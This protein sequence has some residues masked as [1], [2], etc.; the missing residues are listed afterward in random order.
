M[1]GI[2]IVDLSSD[3]E[4][5]EVDVKSVR[6]QPG[7]VQ[8]RLYP[9]PQFVDNSGKLGAMRRGLVPR[10][11]YKIAQIIYM[12]TPCFFILMP[13]HITVAELLD[14][15]IDEIQNGATFVIVDK[16]SNPRDGSPALLIQDDGGGMDPEAMRRC[17]SF[18]FS[19]KKSKS[20][21]GQYGNGFKTS[22]MRLGADV[23]LFSQHLDDRSLTQSI[24]LLSYS[25]LTNAGH[26]RIVVPM[27]DYELNSSSGK[28]DVLHGR[29][30]FA[31]NLSI[32]LQWSPYSTKAEL[33]KQFDNIGTHGTKIII[34]NLWVN[35]DGNSELDFDSDEKD[36][37]IS[38]DTTK[39]NTY[40]SWKPVN[41]QHIARRYHNSLRVYLSILYLRIPETFRII[42]RGEIVEHHNIADD[43]KYIEYILYKPQSAGSV[44]GTVVSTIGFLKEAPQLNI[45]GF[46]VYHKNRLIMRGE[47]ENLKKSNVSDE[48]WTVFVDN[49]SKRVPRSVL[50]EYFNHYGQVVRIFIPRFLEKPKYKSS[51]FA[52]VQYAGEEGRKKAIQYANG[53][54]I[55]GRR[56]NV[57][58]A[59]YQ[60]TKRRNVAVGK[61]MLENRGNMEGLKQTAKGVRNV[62][63]MHILTENSDWVKRSLTGIIKSSFDQD[64]IKE[65]LEFEGV[66]VQISTWGYAWNACL[67]TFNTVEEFSNVWMNKKEEL[68]KMAKPYDDTSGIDSMSSTRSPSITLNTES[69]QNISITS[70]KLN[71]NNFLQ[72]SQSVKLFIR[73]RGKF[74]YLSGT[75]TKPAE[76]DEESERWEAENSMIMSWLINSMDPSVGRTYLFLPTAHDI[77]NAVNETY[78]DLGN[79]GQWALFQKMVE[80]ERVFEFL[81]GLN[82][83]LDEVRGRILG[84][85][86][87][88]STREVFSESPRR[89]DR[90]NDRD[91]PI[92]EHC[93]KPGHTKAK[94]CK[95]HGKLAENFSANRNSRNAK[96]FH[97]SSEDASEE[98]KPASELSAFSKEQLEQLYQLMSSHSISNTPNPSSYIASS[99]LA[100][101]DTYPTAFIASSKSNPWI[102]DSGATDHMIGNSSIFSSYFPLSGNLKV[103][104]ADGSLTSIAGKGSIIIS[105]SLTLLNVLHVPKLSCN[106]I[107][108][109][110]II[111]D[112]KC[113][114]TIT[115]AGFEF[116]DPCS[117]KMIG[118]AKEVDGLYHLVTDNP[119]DKQVKKPRCFT[120]LPC[121]NEIMLWHYR[122]SQPINSQP[123]ETR[124]ETNLEPPTELRVYS[125]RMTQPSNV[126]PVPRKFRDGEAVF[127]ELKALKKNDTWDLTPLPEG[128]RS[129]GSKW[130]FTIKYHADGSVERYKARLVA[131]GFTQTYGLD[132]EETFAPVAK[133]NTVR[134]LLSLAVNLD[135][136]LRQFDVKNAFLNGELE[137]EVFMEVPPGFDE[138]KKDGRVCKLKKSIYGLKQ[139]P[140]AW[141]E[142]FT[143]AVK[144]HG[145]TQA[146]SDHTMFYKHNNGKIAI[147]IVYVDDIVM[148]GDDTIE[149]ESLKNFLSNQFEVEDLGQLKYFLGMEVARSSKGIIISQRKYVLDILKETGLLGCKPVAT[150]IDPNQKLEKED[151]VEPVTRIEKHSKAVYR[152]LHYLKGSPGK[153]IMFS[154]NG[155][156]RVEIFT[157]V[158]WGG[159]STDRRSTTGYCSFVWG[160]LVTWRSKKQLVVS[161][162]SAEAEFRAMAQG[163]YEL[164]WLRRI[165]E[166]LKVE[167]DKPMK[168]YCDNKSAISIAQNPVQHD[169]TKHVEI[170]RHFIKER[171]ENGDICIPFVPSSEQLA[172]VLTKG[173]FTTISVGHLPDESKSRSDLSSAKVLLRVESP[174]D[175]PDTITIGSYGRSFKV[176]ISMGDGRRPTLAV[177]ENQEISEESRLKVISWLNK[178]HN[179]RVNGVSGGQVPS[180]KS[181]KETSN[182]GLSVFLENRTNQIGNHVGLGLRETNDLDD[183]AQLEDNW[184]SSS[185]IKKIIPG[186][187]AYNLKWIGGGEKNFIGRF[188]PD[189]NNISFNLVEVAEEGENE[190]VKE[191]TEGDRVF[192]AHIS[193]DLEMRNVSD[194]KRAGSNKMNDVKEDKQFSLN[195]GSFSSSSSRARKFVNQDGIIP[196]LITEGKIKAKENQMSSFKNLV[197]FLSRRDF[198]SKVRES[199][200][201]ERASSKSS[202]S[203]VK[204][205]DEA[206]A[207]ELKIISWNVG[208]L[209]KR[210][211]VRAVA[212]LIKRNKPVL[213]LLHDTKL[214][215]CQNALWRKL[216]ANLLKGDSFHPVDGSASGL[217]C[218]WNEDFF[219]VSSEHN[220]S[221][222]MA[223]SGKFK[224]FKSANLHR[225][226]FNAY[227]DPEEKSGVSQNWHSMDLFRSFVQQLNLMNLPGLFS[228][229]QGTKKVIRKWPYRNQRGISE[230]I[231]ELKGK[232]NDLE[233]KV[234]GGGIYSQE[235][236]Q[237]LLSRNELWKLHR[238]DESIWFQKS[239]MK[240]IKDGD[241]NTR[242]FHL[243]ALKRNRINAI[244]A[245]KVA[246]VE[247]SN[248]DHIRA[249]VLDF[250]K[251]NYNLKAML[252]VDEIYL[253]FAKL[254][255]K[256]KAGLEVKFSEQEVW[257]AIFYSDSAKS[258][259]LDGYTIGFFKKFW[260]TLK[261]HIMKFVD[262]FYCGRKWEHGVNHAFITLIPKKLNPKDIEDFRPISMVGSLYKIISKVLLKRLV[263]VIKGIVSP[264]QFAF[265]P[266]RQLLDCAF[267]AN[268]GIDFWRKQERKELVFKVD[269]RR[270]YDSMEWPILLTLLKVMGFSEK[271][272]SWIEY[273]ISLASISVLV[274]GSPTEE[275]PMGK[276][277]RQGCSLSPLLFNIVGELLNLM[278]I[279]VAGLGLFEGFAIGR[280]DNPFH[281]TH[282]QFADDL[283]LFYRDSPTHIL[284]IRRVLR[285]FS[286]MSGLHLNLS[287][288]SLY[289][290][291][292]EDDIL[293]EWAYEAGYGVGSFPTV[294]LGLP[295]GA[296][297]NSE[298]LWD[299]VIQKFNNR[300]AGWKASSLSMA[301]RLVLV[302]SVL[303]SL[304]IFF[305]YIFKILFKAS[306]KLNSLMAKF[307]W[308]KGS[309]KKRIHWVNWKMVCQPYEEG[310][311]R[312][313]DLNLVN[314]VLLGSV[315]SRFM[316]LERSGGNFE[317]NKWVWSGLAPPRVETF[318][319][320]DLSS[321]TG[322]ELWNRF[323][324]LWDVSSVLPQDPS[325]LLCS[326]SSLF[327]ISRF[328]LA[329]WFL[330]KFPH[331]L[332]QADLLV[333]DPS[334]A[335]RI[336]NQ[337]FKIK[338]VQCWLP[339]A[340][341][342]KFNMNGAV[343]SDGLQGGIG[344]ILKDS[345][346]TTLATFSN[347]VGPGPPPLAELKA[348]KKGI[349]F[350]LSSYWA[351]RG[352]LIIESD[353]KAAVDWILLPF[354]APTLF[355]SLVGEIGALVSTREIIVR[356]ILRSCTLFLLPLVASSQEPT[357]REPFWHVVSYTVSTGRGVVGVLE[358]NFIEPTHN[359][360]DFE[361]T[362]LF[363][364]LETRL[365]EMTYEY[366]HYHCELIGYQIKRKS[367]P[368]ASHVSPQFTGQSNVQE[369]VGLNQT[370]MVSN[371]SKGR[372]VDFAEQSIPISHG[373][374]TQGLPM[375]RKGQADMVEIEKGKHQAGTCGNTSQLEELRNETVAVQC[376]YERLVEELKSLNVFKDENI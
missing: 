325:S 83:E 117:G 155:S 145:Y 42:L 142:R 354:S 41:E 271:W 162:S 374:S 156:R 315:S 8:P 319:L 46:C 190:P 36:I 144:Q 74:G 206:A 255:A 166:E 139:S 242:F 332:I 194:E 286:L 213:L 307:F 67:I 306:Q 88:S 173:L 153:G 116:Q 64:L 19:D 98:P 129:V 291:N 152:I 164:L 282:L 234:Q 97:A 79:A 246:G 29:E 146:Q 231:S 112:C 275:F 170:D 235:W 147:L 128:K 69:F 247:I 13:P 251:K 174:F 237:L 186:G 339:P 284:N 273:C 105:P 17:M 52:F 43:L 123:R 14:N 134:V 47:R 102:I 27:V 249:Y 212:R 218:L 215:N 133:L 34:Y 287:K 328:R 358:A 171:L 280:P 180:S 38:G 92:C 366:W 11:R 50:R 96:G 30:H 240:W 279:K 254:S 350:F 216:G 33:L 289:V 4:L 28:L 118:N 191:N 189:P 61:M 281:L 182:C 341:F 101:K 338:K 122:I 161:R 345:N 342:F 72:W 99:S 334:L 31:F 252:E 346:C 53:T 12:C 120:T 85:E 318:L 312:V 55:D 131:R 200:E 373:R 183:K 37:R 371:R 330:A 115:F 258:S 349:D 51:T 126:P 18:G 302:K 106:L 372:C 82:K 103:K 238:M 16:T 264:S 148:T 205:R 167:R 54:W 199:L 135:W 236:D 322:R 333:G 347:G 159:S 125:R 357:K 94:C 303:S 2:E 196:V 219:E 292:M 211:K 15:A 93:N 210:E 95:L 243:C 78:S 253:N 296:K 336:P 20:T 119:S 169:M 127:K 265:I 26:D 202:H 124:V 1:N 84:R 263:S 77:W 66:V 58:I 214:N 160:N 288:S 62:W 7:S 177:A 245:L 73:G 138:L 179:S 326:C 150:P 331:V 226:N 299:P 368:P 367:Q 260:P 220:Q 76:E 317:W 22:S 136:T 308:G 111:H 351:L 176:K 329:K 56:I 314:R 157:D 297:K 39:V 178:G 204:A 130:V 108:V 228:L 121:E 266:C 86:P 335:D 309:T 3:D 362:S 353:C 361:R 363:H 181:T 184:V 267:L 114:A 225:G 316:D 24:G 244:S 343:R 376:E 239:R 272:I 168:L 320:A 40:T 222:F 223:L 49:L 113:I 163:V 149:L 104:I 355:S 63:E 57:G 165:L 261:V 300:L 324:R 259:V 270:A 91:R 68:A 71:R 295:L 81:V 70:H 198:R 298:F 90:R 197:Q 364:K 293:K 32:L 195:V 262:D 217:L 229:L 209:G 21:I 310:G 109:N 369:S 301:K 221:R 323:L 285:V 100:Q 9:Q 89:N 321:K 269:F 107:S 132:Y 207:R 60:N 359:K 276:G 290:I 208:G 87:L 44:E 158:D 137:E 248:P 193:D 256:Q 311:L 227:L 340:D 25:F 274:N 23:I 360:Q 188:I 141:F 203:S 356:L 201:Q 151:G 233:V 187:V 230:A 65:A 192:S 224:A 35:N 348:I 110:R 327:F 283:I 10:S 304:L 375:K 313:L 370:Y 337:S 250:F 75:T 232:I 277:L 59:K 305:L 175:V 257:E 268:E 344:G 140:R 241:R 365:K 294:Y 6:L 80:K 45:H 185:L 154:K 143:R 278:L 352:R 172:D 5:G 48:E